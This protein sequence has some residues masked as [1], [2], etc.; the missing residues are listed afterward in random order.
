MRTEDS[1]RCG[2]HLVHLVPPASRCSRV[3]WKHRRHV[4]GHTGRRDASIS[5]ICSRCS[6]GIAPADD[7]TGSPSARRS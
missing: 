3:K 1:F 7:S 6:L 2:R 4:T 5:S